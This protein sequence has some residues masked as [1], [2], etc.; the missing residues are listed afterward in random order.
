MFI[1][2]FVLQAFLIPSESM[3]PTLM[4][5]DRVLVNKLADSPASIERGD[6]VVFKRPPELQDSSINDV[7]KRVI[8]L[9]GDTV[10]G[11]G[12]VLYV[13]NRVLP[14]EYLPPGT[15]TIE[16]PEQTVPEGTL[17]VMGD[18][19]QDSSDSRVFGPIDD[20]LLVGKAIAIFWP[21]EDLGTL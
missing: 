6:V 19:R 8:A 14:E 20:D 17:W 10:K 16:L 7:I 4:V 1:R 2:V 21:L 13:N 5:G 9:P 18:N 3:V 11:R 12:G 15:E